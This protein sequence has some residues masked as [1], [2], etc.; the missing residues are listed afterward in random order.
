MLSRQEHEAFQEI[1]RIL[2]AEDPGLGMPRAT[3]SRT[4]RVRIARNVLTVVAGLAA[5]LCFALGQV[6]GGLAALSLAV[7]AFASGETSGFVRGLARW[8]WPQPMQD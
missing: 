1:E 8:R 3:P 4:R 7:L 6:L 2:V 5:V